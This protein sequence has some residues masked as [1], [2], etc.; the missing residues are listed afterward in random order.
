MILVW[1]KWII[2]FINMK[3][4]LLSFLMSF[5][6]NATFFLT[7]PWYFFFHSSI[8]LFSFLFLRVDFT[9]LFHFW[10][11]VTVVCMKLFSYVIFFSIFPFQLSFLPPPQRHT[12]WCVC[13]S[14]ICLY[15]FFFKY[16]STFMS[17]FLKDV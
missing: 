4:P 14:W 6:F 5:A 1:H 12:F 13:G 10:Y 15:F 7:F 9:M 11:T 2:S 8:I 3:K 17:V 16:S